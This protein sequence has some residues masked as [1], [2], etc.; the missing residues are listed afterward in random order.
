MRDKKGREGDGRLSFWGIK[1]KSKTREIN[2]TLTHT[3]S[4][5]H[6]MRNKEGKKR[7]WSSFIFWGKSNVKVGKAVH[8]THTLSI[9]NLMSKEGKKGMGSLGVKSKV[10]TGKAIHIRQRHTHSRW[11]VKGKRK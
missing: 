3:L 1:S 9:Q 5:V 11:R 10:K 4:R 6:L 2:T 8:I 7:G